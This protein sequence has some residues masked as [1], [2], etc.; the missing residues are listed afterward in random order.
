M[1]LL[2]SAAHPAEKSEAT[3]TDVKAAY[4]LNFMK[5]TKWPATAFPSDDSPLVITCISNSEFAADLERLM[6][7]KRVDDRILKLRPITELDVGNEGFT[8]ANLERLKS[9]LDGS[10]AVFMSDSIRL[11]ARTLIQDVLT[12]NVL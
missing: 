2:V 8:Q 5:F 1:C 11:G 12:K 9:E 3:L 4:L 7:G 6:E 10:H